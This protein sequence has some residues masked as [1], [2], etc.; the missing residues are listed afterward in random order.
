MKITCRLSVLVFAL[1][2]AFTPVVG[3]PGA[4]HPD[5]SG[6][7]KLNVKKSDLPPKFSRADET[8][9]I[10]CSGLT[11]EM[12]SPSVIDGHEVVQIFIADGQ[13][14]TVKETPRIEIE[15]KAFWEKSSLVVVKATHQPLESKKATAV[16]TSRWALSKDGRTLKSE[17]S[18]TGHSQNYVYDK[19]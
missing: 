6:T 18:T 7:W 1:V 15:T 19:Q 11:I 14:R 17:L 5:F 9:V 4:A 2:A 3:Q 8:M 12:K 16:I 10:T 13:S